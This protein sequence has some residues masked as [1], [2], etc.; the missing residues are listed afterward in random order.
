VN[1]LVVIEPA[2]ATDAIESAENVAKAT[3][4]NFIPYP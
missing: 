2:F 1:W 4:I 3:E